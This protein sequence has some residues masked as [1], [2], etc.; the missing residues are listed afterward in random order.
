MT[1]DWLLPVRVRD[2]VLDFH[3]R[4]RGRPCPCFN[5]S[6]KCPTILGGFV[7]AA[8]DFP[9]KFESSFFDGQTVF[10]TAEWDI[11][12]ARQCLSWGKKNKHRISV[13][14]SERLEC[15]IRRGTLK[16]NYYRKRRSILLPHNLPMS[17]LRFCQNCGGNREGGGGSGTSDQ[18]I[19]RAIA[20][21]SADFI[22]IRIVTKI[23]SSVEKT[24]TLKP[25]AM[26]KIEIG[27]AIIWLKFE[28]FKISVGKWI[29]WG[30]YCV[31]AFVKTVICCTVLIE[32]K[33]SLM[34]T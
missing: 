13:C 34:S 17:T 16:Y 8:F 33:Y 4:K 11:I 2:K 15:R 26:M 21:F 9:E 18:T 14:L 7:A 25:A 12:T 3:G 20:W 27:T 30:P 19:A 29:S 5:S 1:V 24:F 32:I 23:E 31:V 10:V 22:T 28:P 6:H